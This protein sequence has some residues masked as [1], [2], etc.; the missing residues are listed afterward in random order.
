M[1][2]ENQ[3]DIYP[4]KKKKSMLTKGVQVITL[5]ILTLICFGAIFH[6]HLEVQ[7]LK[8]IQK[9]VSKLAPQSKLHIGEYKPENV[10]SISPQDLYTVALHKD[11]LNQSGQIAIP[12]VNINLPI[13][14]G[15][16]YFTA[17]LGAGEQYPENIVKM[18]GRGNYVLA[19]HNMQ[20][21]NK[22][23]L[24]FTNL[25][26]A[27]RGEMIYVTNGTEIYSYNITS[28]T[29][30]N[31]NN[32]KPL[33]QDYSKNTITLYTCVSVETDKIL[34]YVVQGELV[35]TTSL[36]DATSAQINAFKKPTSE[37]TPWELKMSKQWYESIK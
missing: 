32:T 14:H 29:Q 13:Q 24:L 9:P 35:E 10:Q 1:K 2:S 23:N 36:T 33:T 20:G 7:V 8:H 5:V 16:D 4:D 31:I 19:S 37:A 26:N 11:E 28:T 15:I 27:K 21:F 30:V 12:S 6:K 17:L 25:N 22:S 18:G 3:R 34:R